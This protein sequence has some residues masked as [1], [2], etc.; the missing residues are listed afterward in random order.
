[1]IGGLHSVAP[2][3]QQPVSSP[4]DATAAAAGKVAITAGVA[5]HDR[6]A[7][8]LRHRAQRPVA[9]AVQVAGLRL[10]TLRERRRGSPHA[11][12]A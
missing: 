2:P 3:P 8:R 9:V 5:Q 4:A 12:R 7:Q 6:F 11:L 1:M 10:T